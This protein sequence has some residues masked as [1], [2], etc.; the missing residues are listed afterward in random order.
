L[1]SRG[2]HG[3][4]AMFPMTRRFAPAVVAVLLAAASASAMEDRFWD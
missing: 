3:T 4:V 2:G 1:S